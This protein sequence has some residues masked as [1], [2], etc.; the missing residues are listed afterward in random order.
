VA[1]AIPFLM[2]R[3]SRKGTAL[4]DSIPIVNW[5]EKLRLLRR[6]KKLCNLSGPWSQKQMYHLSTVAT[7]MVYIVTWLTRNRVRIGNW[8]HRT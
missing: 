6:L 8:I 4:S 1:N 2:I 5:M 7:V 3:T